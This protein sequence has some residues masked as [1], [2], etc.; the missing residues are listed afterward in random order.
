MKTIDEIDAWDALL[1]YLSDVVKATNKHESTFGFE[2]L[3][4]PAAFTISHYN[5]IGVFYDYL[6]SKLRQ[7]TNKPI[8]FCWASPHGLIDIPILQILASPKC[9]DNIVYDCH[10]Y[11]P[12]SIHLLY[13]KFISLLMGRYHEGEFDTL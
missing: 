6:I 4:E 2:L 12:S 7:I 3:N 9:K 1:S 5:K 11:P 13:F 8:V 10:P